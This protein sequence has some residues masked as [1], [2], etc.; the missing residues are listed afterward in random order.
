MNA[1]DWSDRYPLI[2]EEAARIKDAAIIDAEVICV[3]P[4]GVADF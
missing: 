2:F 3:Q 4:D 1:A